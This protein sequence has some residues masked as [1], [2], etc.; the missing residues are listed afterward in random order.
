MDMSK[1][2]MPNMPKMNMDDM[3]LSMMR[4]RFWI[5]ILLCSPLLFLGFMADFFHQEYLSSQSLMWLQFVI[6]IPVVFWCGWMFFVKAG[7]ALFNG[8]LN[9]FTLVVMGVVSAWLYSVFAMF[10]PDYFPSSFHLSDGSVAIYF[11]ASCY[12]TIIVLIGHIWE[13]RG[14][15]T[16]RDNISSLHNVD[17]IMDKVTTNPMKIQKYID[18]IS[19]IFI[20]FVIFLALAAFFGWL[21]YGPQP[22]ALY[23]LIIAITVLLSACPC[24]FTL[25][26][27][28][29]IMCGVNIGAKN[30]ILIK[31]PD[32]FQD[33]E[34]ANAKNNYSVKD[35]ILTL[36]LLDKDKNITFALGTKNLHA[37]ANADVILINDDTK[38]VAEAIKL[39]NLTM[40][41]IRE[42][43]FFGFM[44]NLI[45]LPIAAGILYPSWGILLNPIVASFA[46]SVSSIFVVLNA[47]RLRTKSLS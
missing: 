45:M 36:H 16:I 26:T 42:N 46:M 44:Y 19:E 5:A 18:K 3:M 28:M 38:D 11:D 30:G 25:A 34:E 4:K 12:I 21:E 13:L 7:K 41:N 32:V 33:L 20:L 27:P 35:D 22:S 29:S 23:G 15:K 9:M 1:M 47:L 43:I 8:H 31:N 10:F 17:N 2:N 39:S 37:I 24:V 6:S 40:H 14:R